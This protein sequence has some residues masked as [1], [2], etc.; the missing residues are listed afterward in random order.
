[1]NS[2]NNDLSP[3]QSDILKLLWYAY[4]NP[5]NLYSLSLLICQHDRMA[6]KYVISVNVPCR[7]P[8]TYDAG[9]LRG[10]LVSPFLLLCRTFYI[11]GSYTTVHVPGCDAQ[12]LTIKFEEPIPVGVSEDNILFLR[13]PTIAGCVCHVEVCFLYCSW[14][15]AKKIYCPL[16]DNML[17]VQG[18]ACHHSRSFEVHVEQKKHSFVNLR[19]YVLWAHFIKQKFTLYI[20]KCIFLHSNN[21]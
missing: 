13:V 17:T 19:R 1:M 14:Q 7:I 5:S 20:K 4:V 11:Y 9:C 16:A 6:W 21:W 2:G 18:N 8:K 3:I 15:F 12:V 10:D